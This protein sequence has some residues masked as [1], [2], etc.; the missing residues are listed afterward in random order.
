MIDPRFANTGAQQLPAQ[1]QHTHRHHR[2][3]KHKVRNDQ[4]P[5]SVDESIHKVDHSQPQYYQYS[6]GAPS[7]AGYGVPYNTTGYTA[8]QYPY[9]QQQ[10]YGGAN[11]GQASQYQNAGYGQA[12]YASAPGGPTVKHHR[13]HHRHHRH[14]HAGA[15]Q[16]QVI[17]EQLIGQRSSSALG[18]EHHQHSPVATTEVA[19]GGGGEH[20]SRRRHHRHHRHHHQGHQHHQHHQHQHHHSGENV[21]SAYAQQATSPY[22]T[23]AALD[24]F[25]HINE[26]LIF[27]E[28]GDHSPHR[29]EPPP[30]YE[31]KGKIEVQSFDRETRQ[32][33]TGNQGATG[34]PCPPG[35]TQVVLQGGTCGPCPSGATPYS[36]QTGAG[37]GAAGYGAGASYPSGGA[38]PPNCQVVADYMF[39]SNSGK[40]ISGGYTGQTSQQTETKVTSRPTII[41]VWQRRS[42][43]PV[44]E[45]ERSRS[46]SPKRPDFDFERFRSEILAAIERSLVRETHHRGE[47]TQTIMPTP[48]ETRVIERIHEGSGEV[49]V[50]VQPIQPVFYMPRQTP[51][52]IP[53]VGPTPIAP[54]PIAPQPAAPTIVYVPRNV[55]VPVIKPVFVPR[56][57]IIVRPQVIHVA[58][59][60]LVDRPVPVTQ[61]PIIIDRER[62]V[63]VPVRTAQAA[64]AGGSK[65]VQEEYVYRDNLPV[66]YGGRCAEFAGGVNYGYTPA[67][68]EQQFTSSSVHE[69]GSLYQGQGQ[70]F[71]VNVP[72]QFH[73]SQ[74]SSHV[75]IQ[76]GGAGS[77]NGSFS[78]L[79][80]ATG[81]SAA[82]VG[83]FNQG[84]YQQ[85]FEQSGQVLGGSF[86]QGTQI[87][88]LDPT[89]NPCWQKTD[90]SS[91]VQRY[92]RPAYEIVHKGEEVE[93]QMYR[94]IRQRASSGGVVRS[95]STA[96]YG[97]TSGVG[98][99]P[100]CVNQY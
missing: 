93:Q 27:I 5:V 81:A 91:L 48:S 36:V 49:R 89:V 78:N 94:E 25:G 92:G 38:L 100:V 52:V 54:Q 59:P 88:I 44:R 7:A 58:R 70:A 99:D 41:E 16:T 24:G 26:E 29:Q 83:Q 55:Y 68:Q 60:V 10:Q 56:E 32:A 35:W 87:E 69:T 31:Y 45:R 19:A 77:Y 11:Y 1:Y 63:P 97:S 21:V 2:H 53:T 15:E 62:P 12:A 33:S 71:N 18:E 82:N 96:S 74:T 95:S 84:V 67:Q 66:A 3:H 23:T 51:T 57:R 22:R 90:Q 72:T 76:Q 61:R 47:G 85:T 17:P 43:S 75:E 30:G 40:L 9:Y 8:G 80:E 65:V 73:E 42:K 86:N 4:S 34:G 14:H 6:E 46:R 13:R 39:G 64:Q 28:R 37:Y 98:L 79:A 20:V 50:I